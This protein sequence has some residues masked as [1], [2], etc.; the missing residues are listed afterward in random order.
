MTAEERTQSDN[1]RELRQLATEQLGVFSRAQAL[2]AGLTTGAIT[3]RVRRGSWERILPHVYGIAGVPSSYRRSAMAAA[4]WAGD[5]AV[6][7]HGT[8]GVLW[9]IDG[10]RGPRT[11][12]W[13]P[14]PRNPH[15]EPVVVHRGERVDRADRTAL[16]TIPMTTPIRTLIDIAGRLENDRLLAAMESVFRQNLGT[17][18]RL[19]ARLGALRDSGRPGAGRLASLLE[20]RGDGRPLEST[21]E[22]KVWL[23][24]MRSGLPRPARQHWV[25]TAGGRYRLD[26]AWPGRKLALECDGWEHH[27]NRVAFGKDRERLSEMVAMGWRVLLIT[28]EVGTRQ[29]RRVVRW[30]EMALAA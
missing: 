24:L 1:E 21:L 6:V 13:V 17:P 11:E 28:W 20:Q 4:L 23:L 7:S 22:G 10:V 29:P 9:G 16:G 2:E 14:S 3:R 15:A 18:E 5:G 30:V 27:G 19:A 12:L 8:A 25:T 26:F